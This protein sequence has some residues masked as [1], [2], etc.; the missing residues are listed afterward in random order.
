MSDQNPTS[1]TNSL[2]AAGPATSRRRFLVIALSGATA[3]VLDACR[4]NTPTP[5]P[6]P[7]RTP[8]PLPTQVAAATGTPT[9]AAATSTSTTTPQPAASDTPQPTATPTPSA[10]PFPPGPPSK[11]GL[12]VG[13]NHPQIFDLLATGGVALVKT[14]EYDRNFVAEIKRVSRARWWWRATRRCPRPTWTP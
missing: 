3:V 9:V 14:L 12:F 7:T 11:L 13:Y 5:A 1:I 4:P 8:S 6:T 10:T 2:S